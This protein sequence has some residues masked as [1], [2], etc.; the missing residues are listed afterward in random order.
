MV[1]KRR[2]AHIDATRRHH[3]RA[4][5]SRLAIIIISCAVVIFGLF[6]SSSVQAAGCQGGGPNAGRTV[7][8]CSKTPATGQKCDPRAKSRPTL[9][10]IGLSPLSCRARK[11]RQKPAW[12]CKTVQ[13]LSRTRRCECANPRRGG[14]RINPYAET[15]LLRHA[16]K[17]PLTPAQSKALIAASLSHD[18]A[19][20]LQFTKALR[21][22]GDPVIRYSANLIAAESLAKTD[23]RGNREEIAR[24]VTA[25]RRDRGK[26]RLFPVSDTDFLAALLAQDDGDTE[27]AL[28]YLDAALESEPEF[29]NA[30]VLALRL[31]IGEIV[32]TPSASVHQCLSQYNMLVRRLMRLV[33]FEPCPRMAA[34]VEVYL[35]RWYEQPEKAAP[36]AAARIYL[37]VI[38]WDTKRAREALADFR[39][40]AGGGSCAK[41]ISGTFSGFVKIAD[42]QLK[43]GK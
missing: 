7:K 31:Q 35:S 17:L 22:A 11:R 18:A 20:I 14:G 34:H 38:A 3:G 19:H 12:V 4:Q 13:F 1:S 21:G 9:F 8:A 39:K 33:R 10:P 29:F 43:H 25:L 28:R 36:L 24:L 40:L 41:T 26:V 27:R 16:V 42:Q 32:Q 23:L 30:A 37:S 2:F 5:K 6:F 15:A